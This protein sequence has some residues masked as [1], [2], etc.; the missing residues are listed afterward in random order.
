M[1]S[2]TMPKTEN[3]NWRNAFAVGTCI[4]SAALGA[5]ALRR[6]WDADKV[7]CNVAFIWLGSGLWLAA[8][9]SYRRLRMPMGAIYRL[10]KEGK[11]PK[12]PPLARV[13][14]VGGNLLIVAWLVLLVMRLR[15]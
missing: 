15:S 6:G 1:R 5:L 7:A 9:L 8:R 13:M 11:L 14:I 3:S 4:I 12:D 2:Q 10:A